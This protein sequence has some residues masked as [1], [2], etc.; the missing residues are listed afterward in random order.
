[1]CTDLV[2]LQEIC[3]RMHLLSGAVETTS[4]VTLPAAVR[5]GSVLIA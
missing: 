1:M 5:G 4:A 2:S 3:G